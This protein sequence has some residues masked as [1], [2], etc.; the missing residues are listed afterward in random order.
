MRSRLGDFCR[1]L[2]TLSPDSRTAR[3]W[4]DRYRSEW[5]QAR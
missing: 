5:S 3:E 4:T 2:I 1:D